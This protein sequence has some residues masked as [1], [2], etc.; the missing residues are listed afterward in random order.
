MGRLD[1]ANAPKI[2]VL[3]EIGFW[4]LPAP[5]GTVA[6]LAIL[7]G[8]RAIGSRLPSDPAHHLRF[9]VVRDP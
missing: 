4:V 3:V 2:V 5:I 7:A 1:L 6:M 9:P 8:F